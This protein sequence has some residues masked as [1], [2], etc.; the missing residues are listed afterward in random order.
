MVKA[1]AKRATRPSGGNRASQ[2]P[3]VRA[4]SRLT[5]KGRNRIAHIL[6]VATEMVMANGFAN[7]SLRDVAKRSGI[8]LSNIQ[9]YFSTYE[10]LVEA[11]IH[12]MR[13]KYD[14]GYREHVST[15]DMSPYN[16]LESIIRYWVEDSLNPETAKFFVEYWTI[17][18]QYPRFAALKT[19]TNRR[20]MRRLI[21]HMKAANPEMDTVFR[22]SAALM[23]CAQIEGLMVFHSRG[24]I[25]HPAPAAFRETAIREIL[26]FAMNG[27]RSR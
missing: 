14:K 22:R 8:T 17:C 20:F 21:V 9:Y 23:I 12:H 1:T 3:L 10:G 24:K 5:E 4:R 6:D 25:D 27:A 2:V 18:K 16:H 15:P 7:I 13:A 19:R 11:I 26:A